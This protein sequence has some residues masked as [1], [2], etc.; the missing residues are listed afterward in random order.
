MQPVIPSSA[1]PVYT[2]KPL[3]SVS[4]RLGIPTYIYA[5]VFSSFC[6]VMGLLWDIMW[7]MSIGRD[8]LFAPPHMVIYVGAVVAGLFSAYQILNLTFTKNHPARAG[9][10]RFWGI[11]YG[12][13][14]AMFCVWGAL[15]MLTSAPFDD[16]WH[17][18]Y[19]LDVQILTPPHTILI[20]GIMTVQFGAIVGI[21]ALQNQYRNTLLTPSATSTRLKWLFAIAAGLLLTMLFSMFAESLTRSQ[22]HGSRFYITA[23][24][25]FPFYLTA[26]GR[27]SL[28]RWP[29]TVISGLFMLFLLLPSWVL[30]YFPATPRL[31]PVLNPITHYQPFLFPPLLVLPAFVMDWL[32]HRFDNSATG[33]KVNDWLLAGLIGI[34]FLLVLL[35]VQWP[36]G[37]FL[38]TSPSARNGFFLSYSYGYNRLPDSP[39][40]YA[41]NPERI[42]PLADFAIGFGKALLYAAVSARI[43]LLWGN[44]MKRVVR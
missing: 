34:A 21:L 5:V 20:I 23:A 26:M 33:K 16:W 10:V 27:A 31:G 32:M 42:Q 44:W 22:T 12:S 3:R 38:H 7:H 30:Q 17:N 18:T 29:V 24:I 15:A 6:V 19:G 14:G 41:Y 8:G 1:E 39:Y 28:L 4:W 2:L 13:L 25:V 35:I 43:G 40:R 9:A 11:F 36:F 37:E